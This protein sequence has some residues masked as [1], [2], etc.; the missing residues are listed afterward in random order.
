MNFAYFVLNTYSIFIVFT[1]NYIEKTK[2]KIKEA[3]K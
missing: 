1:V 2:I 3:Q